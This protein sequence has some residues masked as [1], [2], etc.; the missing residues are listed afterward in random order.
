LNGAAFGNGIYVA[1]GDHGAVLTSSDFESWTRRNTL[2]TDLYFDVAFGNGKFVAVGSGRI[3]ISAG[4]AEWSAE[5]NSS[6]LS[7]V[8]FLNDLFVGF[9]SNPEQA[10]GTILTSSDGIVWRTH[11]AGTSDPFR[12]SAYGNGL[13]VAVGGRPDRGTVATSTDGVNW[14]ART[15]PVTGSF[16]G[17]PFVGVAFG[18]GVFVATAGADENGYALVFTSKDGTNWSRQPIDA[19]RQFGLNSVAFG[20]GQ[21]VAVGDQGR[22]FISRDGIVW[23]ER[24]S[25]FAAHLDR[26]SY[27]GTRFVVTGSFGLI[28]SLDGIE[29]KPWS[30]AAQDIPGQLLGIAY[31]ADQ[32]VA[33]G[34]QGVT[35]TSADGINWSYRHRD[36]AQYLKGV[37][38]GNRRFVVAGS[39]AVG[40]TFH[41]QSLASEDSTAWIPHTFAEEGRL[42]SVAFGNGKF[43]ATG[44]SYP[45]TRGRIFTSLDGVAWVEQSWPGSAELNSVI[46]GDG[47]FVAVG[48]TGTIVISSDG[49][50]WTRQTTGVSRALN[51]V[52]HGDGVF[53]SIGVNTVLTSPDARN[54]TAR[55]DR[56]FER[57]RGLTYARGVFL[58]I[59]DAALSSTDGLN[60]TPH[61]LTSGNWT[62]AYGLGRFMTSSLLRSGLLPGGP[63]IR[64]SGLTL[65]A[66]GTVAFFVENDA[67]SALLI[68]TTQDLNTWMPWKTVTA[69]AGLTQI[70][71]NSLGAERRFFRARLVDTPKVP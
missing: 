53:V 64:R 4:G 47:V 51:T 32:F 14:S 8:E 65:R 42:T 30:L 33:V 9:P 71:D 38:F 49:V 5:S 24:A 37:A 66:D 7:S 20:D 6:G 2:V 68:E 23:S 29:W 52:A 55:G 22:A 10:G 57:I 13:Y 17:T 15:V 63:R 25:G 12:A 31:A 1:V 43:V 11:A 28:S 59:G 35:M 60:W 21:F 18:N 39:I 41:F 3:F 56:R 34:E 40:S 61:R 67:P 46:F 19:I 36:P 50:A 70:V 27:I 54:W 62:A 69:S 45:L 58:A 26:I 44:F 48:T 16:L